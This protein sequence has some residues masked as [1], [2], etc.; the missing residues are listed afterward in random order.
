M[1]PDTFRRIITGSVSSSGSVGFSP[2]P[3]PPPPP[4]PGL[5]SGSGTSGI[6]GSVPGSG[7]GSGSGLCPG[8]SISGKLWLFHIIVSLL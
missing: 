4:L 3:P 7:S 8:T 1:L 5:G 2:L 6:S